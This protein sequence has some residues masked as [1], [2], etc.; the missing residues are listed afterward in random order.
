MEKII[1]FDELNE[2]FLESIPFQQV[3]VN[4]QLT[5]KFKWCILLNSGV[6]HLNRIGGPTVLKRM[7][8]LSVGVFWQ[9]DPEIY[10]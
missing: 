6:F 2:M 7:P 3:T 8:Y 4:L 9:F 5:N 1:C 10:T